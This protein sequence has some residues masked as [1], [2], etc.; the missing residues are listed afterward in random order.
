MNDKYNT[1]IEM[2]SINIKRP[3]GSQSLEDNISYA[4]NIPYPPIHKKRNATKML[5][6]SMLQP[7]L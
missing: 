7:Q 1:R 3:I 5:V 4:A 2:N 6:I